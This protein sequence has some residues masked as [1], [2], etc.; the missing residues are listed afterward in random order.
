[1]A[2]VKK[3]DKINPDARYG[4]Y[5]EMHHGAGKPPAV[6]RLMDGT[7][8]VVTAVSSESGKP[9]WYSWEDAVYV[10]ELQVNGFVR[11]EVRQTG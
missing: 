9:G 8:V 11:I 3:E 7:E 4:W 10:G 1:M 6:Y 2:K 5:S